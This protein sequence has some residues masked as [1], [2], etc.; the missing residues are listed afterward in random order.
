MSFTFFNRFLKTMFPEETN[1]TS[2]TL[3]MTTNHTRDLYS[4]LTENPEKSVTFE[5]VIFLLLQQIIFVIATSGN[6]FVIF[7]ILRA[8]GLKDNSN[9]FILNLA[10]ADLF[11]GLA[12]GS[13]ILYIFIPDIGSNVTACLFRFQIISAMTMSSQI[14]VF[15]LSFDRYFSIC[16]SAVYE[17]MVMTK[18]FSVLFAL[19]PWL[20]S[21][22][23]LVPPFFGWNKWNDGI[24]CSFSL[25]LPSEYFWTTAVLVCAF[26]LGS[27]AIYV[28]IFVSV[29]KFYNR[30]CAM[31]EITNADYTL[32]KR[33]KGANLTLLITMVYTICWLP[34]VIFPFAYATGYKKN[35]TFKEA[36]HWL[37]FL[38]VSNSL[39]NPFIYA[40]YKNDFRRASK[41]FCVCCRRAEMYSI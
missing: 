9:I 27:F 12:T 8:L 18:P 15:L 37:V 41:K 5:L 10:I 29:R 17:K 31:N 16:H 39:I 11:T 2:T 6:L 33:I 26:S 19:L 40:W 25:I 36:S 38:G 24:P 3:Q 20:I 1:E 22:I 14:T 28:R 35:T 23:L 30:L 4:N 21:S 13:Q 7:I 34:Y 32:K